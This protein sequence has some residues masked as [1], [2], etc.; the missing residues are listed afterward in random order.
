MLKM[1][2]LALGL[3]SLAASAQENHG[4]HKLGEVAFP[5]SCNVE[6]QSRFNMATA[7][8]HSFEYEA[9]EKEYQAVAAADPNC[10]MAHWGIAMSNYHPLWAPPTSAEMV[11]GTVA[12]EKALKLAGNSGVEA[13]FINAISVFYK[14]GQS[15][16]YGVRVMA[17]VEATERLS[18]N[19]PD[20]DEAAVF[21]ALALIAAGTMDAD[22]TYGVEVKAARILNDVLARQPQHPGVSHYLIHGYDYPALAHLALPAARV[23]AGI[24]PASA[25]AQ[26]MPSHIFTRLGLWEEAVRSNH[27]AED[28]A[29]AY[30]KSNALPGAWDEQLHAIDYLAY[31]YLQLGQTESVKRVMDRMKAISRVDP[32]NFK[33]AYTLSAVPARFALERRA[34][35]EAASLALPANAL[36]IVSWDKFGWARANIHFARAI[37]SARLGNIEAARVEIAE[38]E[39]IRKNL[40]AKK[41]EYDWGTQVEIQRQVAAAWLE[42]ADGRGE[43][44]LDMMQQAATLDESAEK[45]PVTPGSILPA[46]EQ[47]GELL[48]HLQKPAEALLEFEASLKRA[49]GR[50]NSLRGAARAARKS[51]KVKAA[52]TY[53]SQLAALKLN[54]SGD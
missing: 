11:R 40:V 9:A 37:G 48:M 23:Y 35:V 4:D 10:A 14:D 2:A 28:A 47:V 45:H 6:A 19:Y 27:A 20:N 36:G 17:Y 32:P 44:A 29:I 5:I 38:L 34:W 31:G 26:H 8:L 33:V 50:L 43:R 41:G 54:K 49:P 24:A 42:L 3:V 12:A 30:A 46:R 22:P 16:D 39:Q 13:A 21:H 51:G 15:A 25:H 53:N 18:S 52:K 1:F 7:W